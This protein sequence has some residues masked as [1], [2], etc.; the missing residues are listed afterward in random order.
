MTDY[1][2]AESD[3]IALPAGRW[4]PKGGIL[5][6]KAAPEPIRELPADPSEAS[7]SQ[8]IACPVCRA[9]V[10]QRCRTRNGF[11][12][13]PHAVRAT[14]RLCAC[15]SLPEPWASY[16]TRCAKAK[17]RAS[18]WASKQRRKVAA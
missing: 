12:T 1:E 4:I 11:S 17:R 2:P 8:L 3:A 6:F 10:T 5:I 7:I 16:C 9:T 14:P 18:E 13:S 15:G